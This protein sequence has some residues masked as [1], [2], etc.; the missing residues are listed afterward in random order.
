M[1][2]Q[3]HPTAGHKPLMSL[4]A[5]PESPHP[6]PTA[7]CRSPKSLGAPC[8]SRAPQS[9]PRRP[10]SGQSH[11]SP[12]SALL[13]P[14][15]R[16]APPAESHAPINFPRAPPVFTGPPSSPH[17]RAAQTALRLAQIDRWPSH[18]ATRAGLNRL[19][20][21]AQAPCA[22]T[23]L[24]RGPLTSACAPPTSA[25]TPGKTR[26]GPCFFACAPRPQAPALA[27]EFRRQRPSGPPS[28]H[29]AARLQSR[30]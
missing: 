16:G 14:A 6:S 25:G 20:C 9:H 18:A 2:C 4:A 15:L 3:P 28:R 27:S 11:R 13:P 19:A 23:S 24:G 29:G 22:R 12:T 30:A 1:P 10:R 17:S 7:R 21:R 5:P 26:G 8:H